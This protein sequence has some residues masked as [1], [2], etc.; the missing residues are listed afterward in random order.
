MRPQEPHFQ[1]LKQSKGQ[2]PSGGKE[3]KPQEGC[4]MIDISGPILFWKGIYILAG[5]TQRFFV[6]SFNIIDYYK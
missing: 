2:S 1:R 3:H 4:E 6:R 5:G